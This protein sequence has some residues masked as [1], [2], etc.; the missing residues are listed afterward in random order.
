MRKTLGLS[1]ESKPSVINAI[2]AHASVVRLMQLEHD[3]RDECT[4]GQALWDACKEARKPLEARP[5]HS[6]RIIITSKCSDRSRL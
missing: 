6:L 3:M 4:S 2:T 1:E 5:E